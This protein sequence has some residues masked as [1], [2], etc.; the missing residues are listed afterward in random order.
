MDQVYKMSILEIPYNSQG[1][2]P[3]EWNIE[4]TGHFNLK[5]RSHL[6]VK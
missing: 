4:Q 6:E 2:N 3:R 5:K 1:Q